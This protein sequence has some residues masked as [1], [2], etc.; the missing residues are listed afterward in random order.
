VEVTIGFF[1][2]APT[3][4]TGLSTN[5]ISLQWADNATN[6]E[7]YYIERKSASGPFTVIATRPANTTQYD[8]NT[9]LPDSVY[10]Y[11]VRAYFGSVLTA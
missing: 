4:L 9:I 7:G 6:E 10:T 8:D 5:I 11:R 2:S 3:N 1:I